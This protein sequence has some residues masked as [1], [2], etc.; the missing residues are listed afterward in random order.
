MCGVQLKD[1]KRSTDLMCML[2]LNKTIDQLAMANSVRWYAHMLREDGHVLGRSLDF[3]AEGQRKKARAK[4]TWKKQVEEERVKVGL[5]RDAVCLLKWSVGLNQI[6]VGL[7]W[8]WSP[9]I[10]EDIS[11]FSTLVSLTKNYNF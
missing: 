8:I 2:G 3:E 5:R 7:R 10:L 1:R 4:M 9:S 6:A 11:R